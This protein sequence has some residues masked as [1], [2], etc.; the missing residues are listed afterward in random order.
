MFIR[1]YFPCSVYFDTK[2]VDGS[3]EIKTE[4]GE[5]YHNLH[6]VSERTKVNFPKQGLYCVS[7]NCRYITKD[8]QPFNPS[9]EL[10]EPERDHHEKEVKLQIFKETRP[11]SSPARTYAKEGIMLVNEP[12]FLKSNIQQRIFILLHEWAHRY[13]ST[14]YLCDLWAAQK[15]C[16]WGFNPSQAFSTLAE[17]LQTSTNQK[18]T[19]QERRNRERIFTLLQEISIN[20]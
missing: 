12:I 18:E 8:L 9:I 19:K 11:D 13:Y 15:Y 17:L 1:I 20:E 14:E 10:P 4:Q 16:E 6:R 3:F 2:E 7:V 5:V